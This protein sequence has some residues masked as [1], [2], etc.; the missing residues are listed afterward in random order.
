MAALALPPSLAAAD[1]ATGN[2]FGIEAGVEG[3]DLSPVFSSPGAAAPVRSAAF[4]QMARCP[5]AGTLGPE[6]ACN[7]VKLVDIAY[8]GYSVRVD[9]WRYT[10]WMSFNGT[11]N[12][13]DW[14]SVPVPVPVPVPRDD[15]GAAAGARAGAGGG[16]GRLVGAG[17]KG[18]VG[19]ELYSH[20]GD[21]GKDFDAFENENLAAQPAHKATRDELFAM[22]R[23][24]FQ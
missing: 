9:D 8:M 22:L 17:Q 1:P 16:S 2:G 14:G 12:R 7:S 6:S 21:D 24:K 13:A 3:M 18:L 15:A 23:E 20:E 5:A 4:S 10:A 19:E 11:A